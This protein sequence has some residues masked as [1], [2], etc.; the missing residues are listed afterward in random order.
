MSSPMFLRFFWLVS[1]SVPFHTRPQ[2]VVSVL[3]ALSRVSIGRL[4]KVCSGLMVVIAVVF[5][6]GSSSY[7]VLYRVSVVL[8]A[9]GFDPHV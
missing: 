1:V 7:R 5:V 2:D 6:G 4:S 9:L 8:D 3:E